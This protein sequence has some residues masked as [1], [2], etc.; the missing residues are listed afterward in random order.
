MAWLHSLGFFIILL[1]YC[2]FYKLLKH[3]HLLFHLLKV[4]PNDLPENIW[5]KITSNVCGIFSC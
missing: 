4:P 1:Y 3:P 2:E 5:L